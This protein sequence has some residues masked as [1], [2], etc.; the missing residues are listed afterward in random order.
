MGASFHSILETLSQIGAISTHSHRLRAMALRSAIPNMQMMGSC[1][2]P[3]L[4]NC[5][6]GSELGLGSEL[7]IGA[8]LKIHRDS[9]RA[10]LNLLVGASPF[11][12]AFEEED[13]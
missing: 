13:E 7:S 8:P 11:R 12:S 9:K 5:R 4:G 10:D 2:T 3:V 1:V 6:L